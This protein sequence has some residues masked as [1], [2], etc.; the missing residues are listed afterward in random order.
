MQSLL[1]LMEMF[2]ECFLIKTLSNLS[3]S[4][5]F[6]IYFGSYEL[7]L[8]KFGD[9][10]PV[11]LTA[12]GMAGIFSWIFT[13]PQDVIKSRL[14]ADGFGPNQQYSSTRHCIQASLEA[15]GYSCLTRGVGS[16]IIRAFPMNAVTFGVYSYI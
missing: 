11:I 7:M 15:E 5:A 12:G 1:E 2:S 10:T 4:P 6:G 14:Q 3:H 9:S 13:Y 16:T 8:R